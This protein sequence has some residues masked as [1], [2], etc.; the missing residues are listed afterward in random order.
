MISLSQHGPALLTSLISKLD[1]LYST[2]TGRGRGDPIMHM[3]PQV[4]AKVKEVNS[5]FVQ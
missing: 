2:T 4:I 3:I 1:Q 5:Q